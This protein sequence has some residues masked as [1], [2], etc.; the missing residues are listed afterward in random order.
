MSGWTN[1]RAAFSLETESARPEKE[2][3]AAEQAQE[4]Q[5]LV[6]Q[7]E[8]EYRTPLV[9]RYWNECSYQE[10]ADVMDITVAAVK[11]RLFRARKKLAALYEAAQ[12]PHRVEPAQTGPN[13]TEKLNERP[14]DEAVDPAVH[15]VAAGQTAEQEQMWPAPATHSSGALGRRRPVVDQERKM[16]AGK[17]EIH[18]STSHTEEHSDYLMLISLALDGMLDAGEQVR[19]EQHLEKCSGCRL[20]WLLWQVIDQKLYAAPTP[21]PSPDFSLKVSE[22]LSRQ[23]RLRNMQIGMFL[24]VLTVF[25]WALG[26][27][28]A[29]S[30]VG[31]LIYTNFGRFATAGQ[32]LTEAWAVAAVVGQSLWGIVVELTATPTALGVASA[33]LVITAV[34]LAAWCLLIQR[35]AQPVRSRMFG[36]LGQSPS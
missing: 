25:A 35:S 24:T 5:A 4:M 13:L 3:L 33:Y 10:I 30:L 29:C 28:G 15:F 12:Q 34:A 26:L 22:R 21:E 17:P 18:A 19:L 20:H 7:L 8:P 31:T 2:A 27:V 11:S 6:N 16:A 9:L 32:F 36:D 23:E 1:H 14:D